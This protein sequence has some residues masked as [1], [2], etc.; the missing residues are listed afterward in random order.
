MYPN[1]CR[2]GLCWSSESIVISC[3]TEF[4]RL[5]KYSQTLIQYFKYLI[6]DASTRY[7]INIKSD[8]KTYFV[9]LRTTDPSCNIQSRPDSSVP[10]LQSYI[11]L[12]T[13]HDPNIAGSPMQKGCPSLQNRC[14]TLLGFSWLLCKIWSTKIRMCNIL[15]ELELFTS[16]PTTPSSTPVR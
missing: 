3:T 10:C 11:R 14:D 1:N 9:P 7:S 8:R 12:D 13:V 6:Q 16:P 5:D 15:F 4:H 2:I